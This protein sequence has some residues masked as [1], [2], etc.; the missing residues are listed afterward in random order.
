MKLKTTDSKDDSIDEAPQLFIKAENSSIEPNKIWEQEVWYKLWERILEDNNYKEN[1][2]NKFKW[3][4]SQIR[5]HY[6]LNLDIPINLDE[7]NKT[8]F[9]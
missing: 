5:K 6:L 7:V 3:K 4:K 8:K 2:I 1:L 9:S